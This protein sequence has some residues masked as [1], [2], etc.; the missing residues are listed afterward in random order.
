V[1]NH[2]RV[3]ISTDDTLI[4][5]IMLAAT[6]AAEEFQRRT[7]ITR[8]RT[9]Y[10]D[11]F[12]KVIR[13]PYS[14]LATVTSIQ[15]Y[16]TDG[17]LQTLGSANYRVDTDTAPGRITEAYN[18]TWPSTRA[19][20]GAVIVTYTSGYGSNNS[21]VPDDIKAALKMMIAHLYEN[22]TTV[23]DK[24]LHVVPLGARTL[25]WTRKITDC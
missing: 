7:Y 8:S 24:Q 14:P 17:N 23:I 22:R 15:Y 9:Y 3:D 10:L 6:E 5:Q 21:D 16:D 2:L 1:K 11:K 19:M 4:A 13:P 12:P 25:L 18:T 20:T